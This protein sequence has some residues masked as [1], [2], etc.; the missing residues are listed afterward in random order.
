MISAV[1]LGE[2]AALGTAFC[3]AGTALAFAAAGRRIGSLVVN[4]LRL[5]CGLAL[6]TLAAWLARW[7]GPAERCV[8]GRRGLAHPLGPGRLRAR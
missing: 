6:L 7:S 1:R 5:L 4:L 8:S 2:L 3:W